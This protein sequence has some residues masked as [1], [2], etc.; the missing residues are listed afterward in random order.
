MMIECSDTNLQRLEELIDETMPVA[1]I[2]QHVPLKNAS[3]DLAF[4]KS[5]DDLDYLEFA[6]VPL[7]TAQV[8][9][10]RHRHSDVTDI[11]VRHDQLDI[12]NIL[13]E[14]VAKLNLTEND[15]DWVHPEYKEGF[16]QLCK[17]LNTL[18]TFVSYNS[19]D[20]IWA[21]WIAWILE[22]HGC[23]VVIQPWDFRPGSD[24]VLDLQR[25]AAASDRT[26]MIL[27]ESYLKLSYNQS[28]WAAA[29]KQAPESMD[30]L[31][32]PIRVEECKPTGLLRPLVYVDLVGKGEVEAERLVLDAVKVRG[33]PAAR[34]AYPV[35]KVWSKS[36]ARPAYPVVA[37]TSKERLVLSRQLR[38]LTVHAF[39]ELV[40]RLG[41]Q[42]G[43]IPPSSTQ[44]IA[45]ITALLNWAQSSDGCG[46]MEVQ[47]ALNEI[48]RM[49]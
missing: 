16:L 31:L 29:F 5:Y 48:L 23:S 32:L 30:R 13:Y 41:P 18:R 27:S 49:L 17:E 19:D 15:L 7:Q 34:P 9:L 35:N 47:S 12:D 20:R 44:E 40:L 1:V 21:E 38:G 11:C 45:R 43:L 37:L 4:R 33:K 24:F 8:S 46:L 3:H 28:E 42:P 36:A 14:A 10:I 26:I 39:N 6:I 25:A 22:E 2:N